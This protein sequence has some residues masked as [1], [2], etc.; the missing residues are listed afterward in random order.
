MFR[1]KIGC[2]VFV[3][4]LMHAHAQ[5]RPNILFILSDDHAY[6]AIGAYGNKIIA[7]P[8]IDRIAKNGFLFE[9]AVVANSICGPSRATLLTGQ[10]SHKNGYKVNDGEL[11]TAQP[12]VS[13]ILSDHGYQTAWI[14]KWHLG[15]LPQ[16]F[17][18]WRVM[19]VQGH[20]F[21]PDFITQQKDTV[22]YPGYV[23]D[24]I[25]D[26]TE[27]YLDH[28]D[29]SK[30]FFLVVGEKATHREWLPDLS[31]LGRYDDIHFPLPKTFYDDYKG[32]IAAA[33][34]KMEIGEVLTLK[35]DLKM[36]QPFGANQSNNTGKKVSSNL[37]P[38]LYNATMRYYQ[39]GEYGR[40]DSIQSGAYRKY[41]DAIA[42][43]LDSSHLSGNALTE[44]KYQRFLHDY[45][46]TTN[47]MD[48]NIGRLLHYLDR[49]GLSKNTIV[50]YASDQG[51]YLGE[52][53]W[54][55]KRF[56]YE[57]SLRT[58]LIVR[59][60]S[61]T[62]KTQKV[63]QVISNV[64]WAPTI[65]DWAGVLKPTSMQGTSF[66]PVLKNPLLKT[67]DNKAYYHYYETPGPHNVPAHFGIRTDRY[68]L[69]YFY[70][71]QCYWE[72][73]DLKKDPDELDNLN[74]RNAYH[75]IEQKLKS[76]LKK[77]IVRYEDQEAL[78]ILENAQ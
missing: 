64:D 16:G 53:G 29:T 42:R 26:L 33:A 47:S 62:A 45:Y 28:R 20:Y 10:F 73:Y 66:V 44:W 8:N 61:N 74:G 31:D 3:F 48:R 76:E 6:Q 70:G 59:L 21:N 37:S 4:I 14:G 52:H 49:T 35:T 24:I 23:S 56:M 36:H 39:Q 22:I 15:S 13:T 2:L 51:F 46:A 65:L 27:D 32:R 30:P 69:I 12:F 50:V 18:Y 57:P 34:Q 78:D 17:D 5:Q 9:N 40:M 19:P 38:T 54:F 72:L 43:N 60:P 71:S 68:T 41:Y 1:F 67:W 63:E 11:D 77:L 58:P 55:D 75:I 7:T 25:S